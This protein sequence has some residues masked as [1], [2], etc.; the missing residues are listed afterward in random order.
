MVTLKE[1]SIECPVSAQHH[2]SKYGKKFAQCEDCFM[3]N[4]LYSIKEELAGNKTVLSRAEVQIKNS[5]QLEKEDIPVISLIDSSPTERIIPAIEPGFTKKR[6]KLLMTK[7]TV[8]AY[9]NGAINRTKLESSS[10]SE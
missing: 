5:S 1:W 10:S 9:R 3:E 8:T 6:S 7:D 2:I 4:P